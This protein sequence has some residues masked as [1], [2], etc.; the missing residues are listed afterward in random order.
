MPFKPI[1]PSF[2]QQVKSSAAQMQKIAELEELL[3]DLYVYHREQERKYINSPFI[4]EAEV[5]SKKH[6]E[7]AEKIETYI[8]I[9]KGLS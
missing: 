1:H 4:K 8:Q 2:F 6:S 3:Q 9:P 7:L 5:M